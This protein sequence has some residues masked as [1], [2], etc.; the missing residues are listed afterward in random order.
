MT[1]IIAAMRVELE[2]IKS[3]L[4]N[5]QEETASGITFYHGYYRGKEVVCAVSGMGKV[6]AAMCAA[7]MIIKYAPK[8]IINTGVAGALTSDLKQLDCTVAERCVQH[9]VDTSP[10]GDPLGFISGINKIYFD[11]DKTVSEH[12]IECYGEKKPKYCT[13][14]S[15]DVFVIDPAM[16]KRITDLFGASVCD[17]ESASIAQ[18]CYTANTPFAISRAMSDGADENAALDFP[19]MSKAAAD[20]SSKAVLT[21]IEKYGE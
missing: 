8:A 5:L 11:S 20:I 3:N 9:D 21:Y 10:L 12:L 14:A 16:K 15:G 2:L 1:G 19:A 7:T 13:I 18:V 6:S 4:E 17:M